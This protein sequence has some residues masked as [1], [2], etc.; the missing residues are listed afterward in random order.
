MI[1]LGFAVAQI[2]AGAVDQL[3]AEWHTQMSPGERALA[4]ALD[5]LNAAFGTGAEMPI[6]DWNVR[7]L[8]ELAE[9]GGRKDIAD[10]LRDALVLIAD[11]AS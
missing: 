10:C 5:N 4:V 8:A 6:D 7:S 9:I 2:M 11:E 1:A 3:K